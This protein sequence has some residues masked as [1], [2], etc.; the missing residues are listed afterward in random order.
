MNH[1][2]ASSFQSEFLSE[3]S[4][5]QKFTFLA[6]ELCGLPKDKG[7]C[8]GTFIRWFYNATDKVCQEFVYGGCLGNLNR[9]ETKEECSEQCPSDTTNHI[10][11]I[12]GYQVF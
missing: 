8:P 10:E 9:F 4:C 6:A 12:V 1:F 11:G 3:I 5:L 2:I 7:P